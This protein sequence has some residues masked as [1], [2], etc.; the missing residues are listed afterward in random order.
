MSRNTRGCELHSG[1]DG[2]G[3]YTGKSFTETVTSAFA[4]VSAI[5]KRA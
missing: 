3:Q 1:I 4:F 5:F 2:L